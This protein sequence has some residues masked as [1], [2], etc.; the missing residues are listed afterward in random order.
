MQGTVILRTLGVVACAA[1]VAGCH[2]STRS[3]AGQ[4]PVPSQTTMAQA[5][6]TAPPDQ[7]ITAGP[8]E[9]YLAKTDAKM[10]GVSFSIWANGRPVGVISWPGKGLDITKDLRGHSN[11][12]VVQWTRTKKDGTGTLTIGTAKQT[13]LTTHV[14][15]SSPAKGTNKRQ[16]FAAQAPIGR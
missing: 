3:A 8:G 10:H 14:T 6:S 15:P 13:V 5:N 16:F 12:V 1:V 11:V 4:T 7:A 2:P 9:K